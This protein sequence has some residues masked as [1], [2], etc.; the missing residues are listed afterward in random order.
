MAYEQNSEIFRINKDLCSFSQDGK[1]LALANQTNLSIKNTG[2]F[3]DYLTFVFS[4]VI[5]DIKWSPDSEFLLCCNFKKAVIQIFSIYYPEWKFKLT[6]GSS[7]LHSAIWAPDSKHIITV[8]DLKVELSIWDLI[9]YNVVYIEHLKSSAVKGIEFSPNGASLAIII[10]D[11]GQDSVD[12]YKTKDW[13][14]SRKLIC[15]GLTCID[16]LCWS[17]SSEIISIWCAIGGAAKMI[18]YS[19]VTESYEGIFQPA[20]NKSI[21][22]SKN[23]L[24][25]EFDEKLRG[26]EIVRW[27]HSGQLLAI[28]GQNEMIVLLN[29][30]T[31]SPLLQLRLEPVI[32]AGNYLTR[33][34]KESI[35]KVSKDSNK[36]TDKTSICYDRHI[37]EVCERPVNIPIVKSEIL[38]G[39]DPTTSIIH[40]IDILE[41][42][43]CGQY[44]AVRHRIYPGTLWIWDIRTNSIDIL[45]LQNVISG[46]KWH[47]VYPRLLIFNESTY[48]FEWNPNEVLCFN[49]PRGMTALDARWHPSNYTVVICGYNRAMVYHFNNNR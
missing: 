33:I 21:A 11:N 36:S 26:L 30:L 31:W 3:D 16:G 5:E 44:L 37:S 35:V 6:E 13:K 32:K 10:S 38:M 12:V 20:D 17:P 2:T 47:P 28:S 39:G 48:M 9:D 46:I 23:I 25:E 42:S 43:S 4:D 45:L 40:I 19:T 27:M 24:T 49:I 1:F 22:I 41:F 15:D 18:I 7:G 29:C 34:F 8:A 14:L